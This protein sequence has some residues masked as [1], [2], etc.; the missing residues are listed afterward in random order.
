M[1]D[2]DWD[3]EMAKIDKQ[4]GSLS[5]EQLSSLSGANVPA[6]AAGAP[7]AKPGRAGPPGGAGERGT[8]SWAVYA[9]LMLSVALGLGMLVWPY[10][11]RCGPGLF[12]YLGAV[13]VVITSGV[14]SSVWT[15]RHRA[16]RAHALSLLLILW[17]LVLGSLEVLP[18]VGYAKPD[19]NHPS[20]WSC[21]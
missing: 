2:R 19:L 6:K 16:S 7:T 1:A 21:Q 8:S 3:K 5:D 4:L 9:R 11:S 12:A 20:T 14:W 10:P 18:R 15:W 13:A 17:G